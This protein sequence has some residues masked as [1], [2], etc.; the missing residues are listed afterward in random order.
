[1]RKQVITVIL[2]IALIGFIVLGV[3][4]IRNSN[5]KL[6][7]NE[8]ELKSRETQLIELNRKYDQVLQQHTDTK[9]QKEE[10]QKK[11]KELEKQKRQ[12][13]RDLQAKREKQRLD[14]EKLA[15]AAKK[16]TGTQTASAA[17]GTCA[18][19]MAAAGIADT[20]ATR[21]LILKESGCNPRA[22]NPSSGACG[23]P[24]AYPCSKLPNGVNTDP[25]TQLKW[26]QNYVNQRYGSWDNALSTW[27][28][29]CGTKQGCWY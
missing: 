25:V 15:R 23:I 5:Q 21:K 26:M 14:K 1:M 10:Q 28:S 12:L 17:S 29:R 7:F 13:E 19:W 8:I 22:V 16:A 9:Q 24:Q 2:A 11:I 6:Q 4:N 20:E 3:T 27:Y 18:D